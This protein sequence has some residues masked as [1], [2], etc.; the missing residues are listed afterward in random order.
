VLEQEDLPGGL[1]RRRML[2]GSS[3]EI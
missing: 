1:P 2:A 3:A